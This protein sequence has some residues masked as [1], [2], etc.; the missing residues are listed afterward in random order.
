MTIRVDFAFGAINRFK[1]AANTCLKRVALGNTVLI[2][3]ALLDRHAAFEDAFWAAQE[4]TVFIPFHVLT[5]ET[6]EPTQQP[7]NHIYT[8]QEHTLH[9]AQSLNTDTL[10]L[11]NLED[12]CPVEFG[13]V[14]RVLEIVSESPTDIETARMRWLQYKERGFIV[15]GHA[16]K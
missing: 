2:Y 5:A 1:Q 11:L 15:Q 12:T 4:D 7:V 8:C 9:F 10:W 14:Q 13:N 16:L 6:L 3:W